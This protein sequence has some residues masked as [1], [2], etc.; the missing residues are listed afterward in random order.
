MVGYSIILWPYHHSGPLP[1]P[2]HL[3]ALCRTMDKMVRAI[4]TAGSTDR[5]VQQMKG[6]KPITR[7]QG[8]KQS[9]FPC[10]THR[11]KNCYISA[12]ADAA[13][14]QGNH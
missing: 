8:R 3:I 10:K 13:V 1:S 6:D 11:T 7:L 2:Y 5:V 4:A 12:F 9:Q 14:A